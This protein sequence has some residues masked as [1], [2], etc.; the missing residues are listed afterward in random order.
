MHLHDVFKWKTLETLTSNHISL[1]AVSEATLNHKS[2]TSERVSSQ[3]SDDNNNTDFVME[4]EMLNE[5]TINLTSIDGESNKLAQQTVYPSNSW[6]VSKLYTSNSMLTD[7]SLAQN[8]TALLDHSFVSGVTISPSHLLDSIQTSL[9]LHHHLLS[10]EYILAPSLQPVIDSSHITRSD[11]NSRYSPSF[12][13]TVTLTPLLSVSESLS[14]SFIDSSL[15][16]SRSSFITPTP[17]LNSES[18]ENIDHSVPRVRVDALTD[19]NGRP[20]SFTHVSEYSKSP[21]NFNSRG[22]SSISESALVSILSV[23]E[24]LKQETV[25]LSPFHTIEAISFQTP[26]LLTSINPSKSYTIFRQ[27]STSLSTQQ[28][29]DV[30][31]NIVTPEIANELS[32]SSSHISVASFPTEPNL[33]SI[34]EALSRTLSVE[35]LRDTFV[36]PVT[37]TLGLRTILSGASRESFSLP[38]PQSFS[39]TYSFSVMAKDIL[40]EPTE[41]LISVSSLDSF[42]ASLSPQFITSPS[43]MPPSSS[44][45]SASFASSSQTQSYISTG[46]ADVFINTSPTVHLTSASS[47]Y[48]TSSV[49]TLY[50]D[51]SSDAT[52]STTSASLSVFKGTDSSISDKPGSFEISSHSSITLSSYVIEDNHQKLYLEPISFMTHF[53]NTLQLPLVES[54]S[55]VLEGASSFSLLSALTDVTALSTSPA[56]VFVNV[57]LS[58]TNTITPNLSTSNLKLN[59]DL[60]QKDINI[61]ENETKKVKTFWQLHFG[62]MV[63]QKDTR[64][65]KMKQEKEKT[66]INQRHGKAEEMVS[67]VNSVEVVEMANNQHPWGKPVMSKFGLKQLSPSTLEAS[68]WSMLEVRT[69]LHQYSDSIISATTQLTDIPNAI[70]TSRDTVVDDVSRGSKG[71]LMSEINYEIGDKVSTDSFKVTGIANKQHDLDLCPTSASL[72]LTSDTT[73]TSSAISSS[74]LSV[75][76]QPSVTM[77]TVTKCSCIHVDKPLPS[78]NCPKQTGTQPSI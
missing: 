4:T 52:S 19:S 18:V 57:T 50:Y 49:L 24:S 42:L 71:H 33:S 61:F 55:F 20:S 45:L 28:D 31:A 16:L 65:K 23:E 67:Q 66:Q 53:I 14:N 10:P 22:L 37:Q 1:E 62:N 51:S 30:L 72:A 70:S 6:H 69:E 29:L 26:S 73:L 56:S 35:K 63:S 2:L 38:L 47:S 64:I 13:S 58:S 12:H 8:S 15:D 43:S 44:S 9:P 5:K 32:S 77:E 74:L 17:A 75:P 25:D 76:R 36:P 60:L 39:G 40:V 34:K 21:D 11:I 41:R 3:M 54:S 7:I 48:S 46:V 78:E 27:E 59:S 68:E